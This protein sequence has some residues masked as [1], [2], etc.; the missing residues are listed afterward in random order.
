MLENIPL[1]IPFVFAVTTLLTVF[2]FFKA[3]NNSKPVLLVLLILLAVQALVAL[4]G[5]YTNTSALPPRVIFL[6]PPVLILIVLLFITKRGQKFLDHLNPELLT[7]LHII[8]VPVEVVLYWLFVQKTIPE[9]MTFEGRNFD[10]LSGM[11]AP[12][13]YYFGFIKKQLSKAVILLWNFVCL[14]LLFN[15]VIHAV[16]SVPYPFQMLAFDQPN[17]AI[18]YFP[19]VWLPGCVVP[20]VL[21]AHLATIRKLMKQV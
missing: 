19:F 4:K 21:L 12:F 7:L 3:A 6:A 9:L 2:L 18:L 13:V 10:I 1:H 15:V 5:F 11:S 16:L 8:R 17:I 14:G 20:L